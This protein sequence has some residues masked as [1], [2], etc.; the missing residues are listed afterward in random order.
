MMLMNDM[1][2]MSRA[3]TGPDTDSGK[4]G[5]MSRTADVIFVWLDVRLQLELD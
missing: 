2:S 4:R 3:R 5:M 1:M